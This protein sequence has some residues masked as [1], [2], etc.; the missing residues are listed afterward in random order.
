M[1]PLP[2]FAKARRLELFRNRNTRCCESL[3]VEREIFI[4]LF[5]LEML[6]FKKQ[7]HRILQR[8]GGT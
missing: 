6:N 3:K 7:A 5:L 2:P 4:A 8:S 1:L